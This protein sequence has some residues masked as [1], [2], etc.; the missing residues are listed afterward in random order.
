ME[1]GSRRVHL[2]GCTTNPT[3]ACVSQHAR[4]LG[5]TDVLE[6]TRFL[7]HDRDSKLRAAFDEVFRSESRYQPPARRVA[8][9]T[10]LFCLKRQRTGRTVRV[11]ARLRTLRFA[12]ACR[13]DDSRDLQHVS[14][15][16]SRLQLVERD[17]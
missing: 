9:V 2:A 13:N 12:A 11:H 15:W 3:G 10:G 7:I 4:N 17:F 8:A 1:L 14:V 6:R 5:F 16:R